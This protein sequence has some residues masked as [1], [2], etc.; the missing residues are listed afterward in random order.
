MLSTNSHFPDLLKCSP[1]DVGGNITFYIIKA[2]GLMN[3]C[4]VMSIS[5]IKTDLA[6]LYLF[7][8]GALEN[9]PGFRASQQDV[10]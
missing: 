10:L 6:L 4:Q 9:G 1:E 7:S 8:A 2:Y 5:L 3:M